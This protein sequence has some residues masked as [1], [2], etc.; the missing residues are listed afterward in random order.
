[1]KYIKYFVLLLYVMV[2]IGCQEDVVPKIEQHG[3]L[4]A[5]FEL[6]VNFTD[7][8]LA[9]ISNDRRYIVNL[10]SKSKVLT[11]KNLYEMMYTHQVDY[12]LPQIFYYIPM[13]LNLDSEEV[14]NNY[15]DAWETAL[16]E[17]DITSVTY[18]LDQ[19]DV[20]EY[21]EDQLTNEAKKEL[22]ASS[23]VILKK[24]K[25]LYL[26]EFEHYKKKIW[27]VRAN[28]LYK[29]AQYI[30]E[31]L[32]AFNL[33]NK[34]ESKTSLLFDNASL[35]I[36]LSYY[37]NLELD[38]VS[39]QSDKIVIYY[40]KDKDP[41]EIVSEIS[42]LYGRK[43]FMTHTETMLSEVFDEYSILKEDYPL[44]QILNDLVDGVVSDYNSDITYVIEFKG[45]EPYES[46][47]SNKKNLTG[48]EYLEDNMTRYLSDLMYEKPYL[49]DGELHYLGNVYNRRDINENV[50]LYYFPFYP[51]VIQN[52]TGLHVIT[53]NMDSVPE[54]SP[55][56]DRVLFI[57]PFAWEE[58]GELYIYTIAEE[59]LE[60]IIPKSYE[61][62]STI[63]VARWLDEERILYIDGY[64]YGTV[65]RGGELKEYNLITKTS[66]LLVS[67]DDPHLEVSNI[68]KLE[69]KWYYTI[70]IHDEEYMNYTE[71]NH[72]L[73]IN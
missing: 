24:A 60:K 46:F 33:K 27:P 14:W 25:S 49:I 43:L 10:P 35:K 19:T 34:W 71:E 62:Q 20:K 31:M 15:F 1:M 52:D 51:I 7:H 59:T 29:K 13:Q 3:E 11:E 38:F 56:G 64:P 4:Y 17:G 21:I 16:I 23:L 68:Y 6:G 12:L 26:D 67:Y 65:T 36:S 5:D 47:K 45:I 42:F 32:T 18:Y 30:N 72:E 2:L 61:D 66:K 22:Y 48:L 58:V 9:L 55:N 50:T 39:I 63:K 37:D 44:Y 54:V 28:E 73:K 40:D 70:T 41:S 8:M 57:T 69:D 53:N